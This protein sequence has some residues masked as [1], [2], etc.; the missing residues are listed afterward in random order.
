MN[1]KFTEKAEKALNGA[2][3]VAESF[4][5]TYI[6]TEHVL[7][8]LALEKLSCASVLLARCKVTDTRV[9]EA[10]REYSGVGAHSR[11]T[12][13]DMTPRCRRAVEASYTASQRFGAARI[14]TE[15]ILFA[16]LEEKECVAVKILR[17]LG[18]DLVNLKDEL[19]TFLRTAEKV[20]QSTKSEAASL[21]ILTQYARNLNLAAESGECDPVIG[22]ERKIGRLVRI[23]CRKSKNNPCLIGEAGVG[24]TA[25][26]EG[27]AAR[28][29]R[30]E[31]P[32]QLFGKIIL[33]LDL[34]SMVA[35]TKYRGDFEERI[36]NVIAEAAKNP[37]VILFIDEIHTIVGAGSA[38]GAIDAANILK[39][40]LSRG[41]IRVIGAT[42]PQEYRKYIEKDAALERRFQ[43][44]TVEEPTKEEAMT[45]LRG[46]RE[47]YEK[48]HGLHITDDA[49][50]AAVFL[51]DRYLP[52]RRLPDKALD[53]LYEACAKVTV[54][55]PD[56]EEK[57][58]VSEEKLR[59]IEVQKEEAVKA[60]DFSLALSLKDLES[61]CRKEVSDERERALRRRAELSVGE[62][63]IRAVLTEMTGIPAS[64]L[65]EGIR[66]ENI[67]RLLSE[68][69]IGQPDAVKGVSDA[70]LR[71]FSGITDPHRPIGVFL[72]LGDSG[73]G[74]TALAAALA[75]AL[76][77]S[78][79]SFLRYD[80]S[81]FSERHS[82]SKLIG[83]PPGYVGYEEGGT[84]TEKIRRHPFSVVLFDEI[85]KAHPEVRNLLLQ[86]A[87][88]GSLTDSMGRRVSFRNA[89]VIMTSN[90][91]S[92][93]YK[94]VN[95]SGFFADRPADDEN[96]S[97]L[98][99]YFRPELINRIDAIIR[100]SPL[101][102]E[103][104]TAIAEKKLA[105]LSA[106]LDAVG[107]TVTFAPEIAPYLAKKSKKSGYGAR[108]LARLI[109]DRI[110]N[111]LSEQIATGKIGKSAAL[112]ILCMDGEIKIEEATEIPL[113]P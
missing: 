110:E 41:K 17:Y 81:E 4:G 45:M 16:L 18:T 95:V 78:E 43:P 5:H 84:L 86:I 77:P 29:A 54:E 76:F 9:S 59:Q 35:G 10:I 26:V 14:G 57:L 112:R 113:L 103:A 32:T 63:E 21:G 47:R 109:V 31:V 11:L 12:A 111:P 85:E 67:Y 108:P 79:D 102:E 74:K 83:S 34:T 22:R 39:P 23:L 100:F 48:H 89:C 99:G 28:I 56:D 7:L 37:Q 105:E 52:D 25:I 64:G 65:S 53:L 72:F 42:T 93:G 38:E 69:I 27:L 75:N 104:L 8:S 2:V 94:N 30:R 3:G 55:L 106:R 50:R 62:D 61:L 60:Q 80:M 46:V 20:T 107:L 87:D 96:D 6:G 97:F 91:G 24:K 98:K 90:V 92:D 88:D 36:K 49:L 33:S 101:D 71:H 40:E 66:Y 44:L 1:S 73:V 19:V 15:H 82:V 51:T 58:K 13:K 68:E 70:I